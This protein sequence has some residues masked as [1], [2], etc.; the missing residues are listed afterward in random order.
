MICFYILIKMTLVQLAKQQN[1]FYIIGKPRI[2]AATTPAY[3][4]FLRE[5]GYGDLDSCSA[6]GFAK[7]ILGIDQTVR[8]AAA[9]VNLN[10]QEDNIGSI[11]NITHL[12]ARKLVKALRY[13]LPT[14]RLMYKLFIP[15]IKKQAQNGN[16]EAQATLERMTGELTTTAK[17]EWLED[18]ILDRTRLK[19]GTQERTLTL[20][21]KDG[22]FD[23]SQVSELG[24]PT[25]VKCRGEFYHWHVSGDKRAAFR[26]RGSELDLGLNWEPSFAGDYLGVRPVKI[27][28]RK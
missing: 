11:S 1:G 26:Y 27:F 9:R 6:I 2:L 16:P 13:R 25:S 12:N 20:P 24:Y 10:L 5:A 8:D 15:W 17:A 14:V 19:I 22:Y 28:H 18:L 21:D 3:R 23:R 7:N 4:K